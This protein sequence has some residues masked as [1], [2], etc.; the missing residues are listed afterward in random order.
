VNRNTAAA[1]VSIDA[2]SAVFRAGAPNMISAAAT[3]GQNIVNR[4]IS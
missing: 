1:N 2:A 4:T 3:M